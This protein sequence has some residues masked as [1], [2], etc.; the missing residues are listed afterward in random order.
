MAAV[1]QLAMARPEPVVRRALKDAADNK[2]LSVYGLP[3]KGSLVASKVLPHRLLVPLMNRV[4][5]RA[6]EETDTE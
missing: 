6:S 1:K 3:M 5:N 4:L 2:E